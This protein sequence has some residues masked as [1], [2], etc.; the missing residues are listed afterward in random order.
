MQ[1]GGGAADMPVFCEAEHL[2][3]SSCVQ[4]AQQA[5]LGSLCCINQRIKPAAAAVLMAAGCCLRRAVQPV[6]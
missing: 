6:H 4:P 3:G 1:S 2:R 5:M